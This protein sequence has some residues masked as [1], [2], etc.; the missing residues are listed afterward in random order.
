MHY[1]FV[2]VKIGLFARKNEVRMGKQFPHELISI[3]IIW[4]Y[5]NSDQET[6]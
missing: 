4:M 6:E 2:F 5:D 1:I 3:M